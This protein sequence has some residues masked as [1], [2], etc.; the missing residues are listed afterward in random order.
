MLK[1]VSFL[2]IIFISSF[3]FGNEKKYSFE[4]LVF[5]GINSSYEV[6][7]IDNKLNNLNTVNLLK[8]IIQPSLSLTFNSNFINLSTS[9]SISSI[10]MAN[11]KIFRYNL[12]K[13][14]NSLNKKQKKNEIIYRIL[15]LYS[16]IYN[17]KE[18]LDLYLK[19][20]EI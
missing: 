8:D 1:R 20:N 2:I 16:M 3:V 14:Y 15:N 13:E 12:E 19:I 10:I 5:S 17:E 11:S 9:I 7:M 4:R 6:K 18:S